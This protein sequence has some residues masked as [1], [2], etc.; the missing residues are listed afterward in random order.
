[1]MMMAS[2]TPKLLREA[3][4]FLTTTL[5]SLLLPLSFLLV[6]RLSCS[7]Y[8]SPVPYGPFS[9]ARSLFL[10]TNPTLLLT[11]LSLLGMAT[12]MHCSTGFLPGRRQAVRRPWIYAAWVLL[13]ALQI[14][15]LLVIE[16][17]IGIATVSSTAHDGSG[18]VTGEGGLLGRI[19]FFLGLH[20]TMLHWV[21]VVVKPVVDDSILGGHRDERWHERVAMAA[22]LGRLWWWRLREEV[23][24]IAVVP[25][26][27]REL[28][29]GLGAA[30]FMGRWLYYLT[31][32]IGAVKVAKGLLWAGTILILRSL[33]IERRIQENSGADIPGEDDKV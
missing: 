32:T 22:G 23:G 33:T 28:L 8:F 21:R 29:M 16:G 15:V 14:C 31:L 19:A 20:E 11:L 6:A 18:P 10:D 2:S 5:L 17:S 27:K 24:A 9:S 7:S 4:H 25:E 13:C 12:L 26:V 3:F 30:D 1:M